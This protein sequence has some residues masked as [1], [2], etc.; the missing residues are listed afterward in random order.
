M[1]ARVFVCSKDE[2]EAL[3]KLLEYDPAL[4]KSLSNEALHKLQ[5]DKYGSVIF[6]R[7]EFSLREGRSFGMNDESFYLYL[8]A[9][10]DFIKRA[11][12]RFAHEFKTIKYADPAAEQK[13]IAV[14]MDE[15]NKANQG[16]GA[17]FGG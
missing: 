2:V 11:T 1:A 8:K 6:A 16:F 4:D 14:I 7:K 12:E 5:E 9:E 10:D 17:I 15:E 3:K 13:L